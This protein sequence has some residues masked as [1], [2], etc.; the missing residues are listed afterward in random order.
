MEGRSFDER[1]RGEGREDFTPA[2]VVARE[3]CLAALKILVRYSG[4]NC[5]RREIR[6]PEGESVYQLAFNNRHR[7]METM[8]P[9]PPRGDCNLGSSGQV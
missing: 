4:G 3:G 5:I 8:D 2:H 7:D 9:S 6:T 1:E